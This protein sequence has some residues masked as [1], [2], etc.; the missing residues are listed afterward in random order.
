MKYKDQNGKNKFK[1]DLGKSK[2]KFKNK[3][4]LFSRQKRLVTV[5]RKKLQQQ[6]LDALKQQK[7]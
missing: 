3:I 4:F 2:N 7:Q 6:Q 1:E 5:L